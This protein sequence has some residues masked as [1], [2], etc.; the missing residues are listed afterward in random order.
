MT[1]GTKAVRQINYTFPNGYRP[2][3]Q[4]DIITFAQNIFGQS[5]Q[6]A[7]ITFGHND[8]WPQ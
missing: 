3:R 1:I 7:T 5:R 4:L 8:N 6:L 2:Q